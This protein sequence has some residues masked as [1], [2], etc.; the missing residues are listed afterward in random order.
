MEYDVVVVGG[1]PGWPGHGHPPEATGR[2]RRQGHVSV[3]VLEKGSEPGAHILSG[4]IMDP[5][6]AE[7]NSSPTGKPTR[8]ARS[9]RPVTGDAMVFLG[10][11][12]IVS[13]A[14]HGCCLACFQNHGNYIVRL[15]NVVRLAG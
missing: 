15:G 5:H 2:R 10:E 14:Q 12:D 9:T 1:G 6:R 8:R 4:A 13:H 3:V 7:R 11:K